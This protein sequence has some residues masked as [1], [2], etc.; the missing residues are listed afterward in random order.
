MRSATAAE[1]GPRAVTAAVSGGEAHGHIKAIVNAIRPAVEK[2]KGQPGDLVENA[3]RANVN[4]TVK[5][6][7]VAAPILPDRIKAGKLTIVGARYDLDDGHVEF[8]K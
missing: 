8:F 6:L 3:I 1:P 2:V 4:E 7:R 5:K